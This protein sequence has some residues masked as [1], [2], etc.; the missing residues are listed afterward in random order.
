MAT[1]TWEVY[2]NTPGW[3][4]VGSNTIVFS[5]DSTDLSV[6]IT[7]GNWNSGTHL[8]TGDPGSDQ[9]G[10][11]HIPNVEFVTTTQFKLNGGSTE[12]IN[13]TNLTIT[14]CSMRINFTDASS[15]ATS[16]A[17]FY[18]FDGSTETAEAVG[19]EAYAFERGVGASAWTQLNDDSANIGGDNSGERLSLSDQSAD[20]EHTFYVCVSARPESV[21]SKTEFD[22]GIALTYS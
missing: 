14:E 12:N 1:F 18:A 3:M 2:A 21:G 5:G 17:R 11:T 9:C 10:T 15:V 4:G 6:P 7:V 19:I 20:T 8:G 13:D 22:F 16:N